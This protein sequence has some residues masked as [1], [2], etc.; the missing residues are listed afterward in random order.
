MLAAAE[1]GGENAG[2]SQASGLRSNPKLKSLG[3]SGKRALGGGREGGGVSGGAAERM[4]GAI[5]ESRRG[6]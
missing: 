1:G 2:A 6:S 4:E 3:D 5:G